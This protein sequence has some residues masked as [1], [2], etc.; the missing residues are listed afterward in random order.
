MIGDTMN[1][2]AAVVAGHLL[3]TISLARRRRARGVSAALAWDTKASWSVKR[4]LD[5]S[6]PPPGGL[7]R[8]A[9]QRPPND[10]TSLDI[11]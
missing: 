2:F 6:T 1:S 9:R 7:L 5:S 4:F 11:T 8:S 3:S 10:T